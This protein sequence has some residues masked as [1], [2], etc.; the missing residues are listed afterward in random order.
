MD[1]L[2]QN[3]VCLIKTNELLTRLFPFRKAGLNV[4]HNKLAKSFS[5]LL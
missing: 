1:E 3:T 4:L 2:L 5:L